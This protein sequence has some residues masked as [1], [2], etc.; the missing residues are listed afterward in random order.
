MKVLE[1][2]VKDEV[3]EEEVED[4]VQEMEVVEVYDRAEV[5]DAI[6]SWLLLVS[7]QSRAPWPEG[8]GEE[9]SAVLTHQSDRLDPFHSFQ[10]SSSRT[11]RGRAMTVV[12]GSRNSQGRLH[13]KVLLAFSSGEEVEGTFYQGR[14]E[15]WGRVRSPGRGLTELTGS[16]SQDQLTGLVDCDFTDGTR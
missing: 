14:R 5:L 10:W 16:W 11:H 1:K 9:M 3:E 6:S 4:E 12:G 7:D 13:G 15:G 8:E 2:E